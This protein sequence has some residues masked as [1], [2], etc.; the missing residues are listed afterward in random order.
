[1]VLEVKWTAHQGQ[2]EE[3]PREYYL[4]GQWYLHWWGRANNCNVV[5]FLQRTPGALPFIH[6]M[7]YNPEV[8]QW[9]EEEAKAFMELVTQGIPPDPQTV[10]ERKQVALSLLPPAEDVWNDPPQNLV[11]LGNKIIELTERIKEL[12]DQKGA[13][14]AEFLEALAQ[15]KKTKVKTGAW[16]ASIVERQGAVRWA[17]VAKALNP[18]QELIEKYRGSN[19]RFLQVRPAKANGL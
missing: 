11:E 16:T 14:E 2:W 8:G 15:A 10:E 6:D 17:E 1:M 19:S 18:P 12:E 7:P 4:Q 13:L 5:R 9:L 3:I